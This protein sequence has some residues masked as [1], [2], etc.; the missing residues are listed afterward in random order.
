MTA[1]RT[2]STFERFERYL[3]WR[4]VLDDPP[5]ELDLADAGLEVADLQARAPALQRALAAM[6]DLEAGAK[7][8]RDED[9]MVGHYWLRAPGRAPTPALGD[10]IRSTIEA[11]ETFAA[12]VHGGQLTPA[13]GGVF[14]KVAVIGIG[15]SALG[16]MLIA[17]AFEA[18]AAPMTVHVLDNTDPDGVD[19]LRGRLG[20]MHDVL[21][22]VISKSG[23]TAETRNGM[24]EMMQ[25]CT[26]DGVDFASRAVAITQPGS[27]LAR[28]AET[29]N[30]LGVFPIQNWV[31]GRTSLFAAVGLLPAAL[32]GIDIRALLAG[33][34]AMD[35]RT[36]DPVLHSNPA[37]L[38]ATFWHQQGRGRG[39]RAMVVLPYKDR[40]LLLSR[41]L[42]QLVMESL[43]KERDRQGA[44]VHQG[45]SVFGNKGSTDQH[46][47]V[48]QLRDGRH[49]FFAV[50]VRVLEDR[51]GADLEVEPGVN[52]GDFL[53]GFLQGT[54]RAL[55]EG[56]RN[57]ATIT[58]DRIDERALG[59]LIALFERAVGLYAELIDVNAY[60]QPGVEAGKKAA[61]AVLQLQGRVVAA[62]GREPRTAVAI[63]GQL[64]AEV[65][66]VWMV[67]RH[68]AANR[69]DV[70]LRG[71]PDPETARFGLA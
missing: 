46:A 28:R 58:L 35:E 27:G 65:F 50:F 17:D 45:L 34:A 71:A 61:T 29:E 20:S 22:L 31:G 10:E 5:L 25:A 43:G 7:A 36:R 52:T 49:D 39:E 14:T 63:A 24:L 8:N 53:D 1:V 54:R 13:E 15:G 42:Q 51:A 21:V 32:Q 3:R 11:I 18:P 38:L 47:Y 4:S 59:A 56:G 37:V 19:R 6:A 70:V 23:G 68:L 57:S 30:W 16:P 9:R 48:Q 2:G 55:F 64:D 26:A 62:L 44:I 33:A 67:L 40:L 69:P 66:D 41:Y 12:R 60:H